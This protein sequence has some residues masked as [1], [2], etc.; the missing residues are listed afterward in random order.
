ML[1][2]ALTGAAWA[3]IPRTDTG[4]PDLTGT[5]N[6]ATLTP[7]QRPEAFGDSLYLSPEEAEQLTARAASLVERLSQSSDP[8]RE[9]PPKG[10]NVGGYNFF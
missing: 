3:E 10:A 2:R 5:F 7:L 6:V 4:R 8:N 1:G 9:A